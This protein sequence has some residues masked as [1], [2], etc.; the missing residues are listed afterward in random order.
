MTRRTGSDKEL[1]D[2]AFNIAKNP[3]NDG[4]QHKFASMVYKF[5]DKKSEGAAVKRAAKSAIESKTDTRTDKSAIS[6]Q[7]PICVPDIY[8]GK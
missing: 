7:Q 1:P 4:N 5:L 8:F 2:K 3:K 6:N